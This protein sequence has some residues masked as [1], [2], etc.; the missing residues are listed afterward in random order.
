[1]IHW[2]TAT[3]IMLIMAGSADSGAELSLISASDKSSPILLPDNVVRILP[4]ICS[5]GSAEASDCM[6]SVG[7]ASVV[8]KI[9]SEITG[10]PDN[11]AKILPNVCSAG[12]AEASDCMDGVRLTSVA[13]RV[14]SEITGKFGIVVF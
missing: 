3:G 1:M 13:N 4:N 6:G 11:V 5:A 8:D 12:S 9:R 2:L 10:E 14:K 7:L